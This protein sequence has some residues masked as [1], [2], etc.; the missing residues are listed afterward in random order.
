MLTR[1]YVVVV[2]VLAVY[3]RKTVKQN[4]KEEKKDV[5]NSEMQ[6]RVRKGEKKVEG[7]MHTYYDY[8]FRFSVLVLSEIISWQGQLQVF[9]GGNHY[10][11]VAVLAR[12]PD[13]NL[14]EDSS[15]FDSSISFFYRLLQR[16]LTT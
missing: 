7:R 3:A 5:K 16:S 8:Y 2:T 4:A 11:L 13:L 10:R 6:E 9:T 15:L 1:V 12:G 14:P